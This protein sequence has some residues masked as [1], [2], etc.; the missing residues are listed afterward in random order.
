M[1][2]DIQAAWAS[3]EIA[4]LV[5]SNQRAFFGGWGTVGGWSVYAGREGSR[6]WPLADGVISADNATHDE[7]KMALEY[8]RPNEG[9]HGILTALGQSLAYL[10]KGYDASF[11][12]IPDSYVSHSTPGPH[13]K[14]ILESIAPTSPITIYTYDDPD[15]SSTRPFRGKLHCVRDITLPS[16]TKVVSTATMPTGSVS[17][18]WAHIREGMSHPNAFFRYC[19]GIKAINSSIREDLSDIVFPAELIK[20]VKTIDPAADVYKY[21]SNTAGDSISDKA[22]RSAWFRYYFWNDLMP[23]YSSKC[24]YIVNDQV[25]K[26]KTMYPINQGLF[27]GRSDSRKNILVYKLNAG[28]ITEDNAWIEYAIRVRKDAHSYREVIDSGLFHIGFLTEGGNLS[29]LG[30]KYVD[31]CEK[32]NDSNTGIPLEILRAAVLQNGQ[33]GAFLHYVYQLSEEKFSANPLAFTT[34]TAGGRYSF[35]QTEYK[36]W[37]YDVFANDLHLIATSTI[38]AGGTRNP[39]QAEIPL[40][41]QL[42]FIKETTPVSP[43]YKTKPKYRIGV[44]FEIDWPKVQNSMM[45][46]LSL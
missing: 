44:G 9:L 36:Q 33:Y 7:V 20:A 3:S 18:L 16:C 30:Y 27:S 5:N 14:R 12:V 4:N 8:K 19:Q 46:A 17:T 25:T 37:L 28:T 31:A 26:I 39:F 32:I 10:E 43:A 35:H 23:I 13:L 42:G 34:L 41:K 40:L 45:Y 29:D 15:S 11:I 6:Q 38:R 21:L 2:H 24:P 22:W 1:S